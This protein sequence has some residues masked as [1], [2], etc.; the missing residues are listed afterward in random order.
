MQAKEQA[1]RAQIEIDRSDYKHER[2]TY[3]MREHLRKVR[4]MTSYVRQAQ[5][6]QGYQPPRETARE[7]CYTQKDARRRSEP[8][9]RG[10]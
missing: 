4:R 3:G 8:V 6:W 1:S 7:H 5:N 2:P 9:A 10:D